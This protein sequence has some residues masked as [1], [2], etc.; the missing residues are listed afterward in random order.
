LAINSVQVFLHL[1]FD[2]P[3]WALLFVPPRLLGTSMVLALI[4]H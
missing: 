4:D 2:V 3:L 1:Y